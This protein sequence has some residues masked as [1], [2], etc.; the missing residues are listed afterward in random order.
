M[1][2][3]R[4][5]WWLFL[6]ALALGGLLLLRLAPGKGEDEVWEAIEGRGVIRVGT[7]ASYP[8]F[9]VWDE[10]GLRGFDV[11]LA[12]ELGRELGVEVE[13]QNIT[14]DGLY[15]ALE[16]KKID[17]IMSALP[18]DPLM[19]Q[20]VAYSYA[21]LDAG[22]VLVVREGADIKALEDLEGSTVGLE[23]GSRGD[24]EVRRLEQR[25]N[26]T[27]KAYLTPQ[28]ALEGLRKGVVEAAIVDAVSAYQF[29]G[30]GLRIALQVSEEPYVIAVPFGSPILLERVNGAIIKWRETGYLEDLGKRWF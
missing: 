23:L 11:D 8:P 9:E 29:L 15:E 30:E 10:E 1:N 2:R 21:Y 19:T 13:F 26:L 28:E 25:M 20:D 7:D 27:R 3:L 18:Y 24:L 12:R 5:R 17:L 6:I 16:A 22:Q 14:F 4:R